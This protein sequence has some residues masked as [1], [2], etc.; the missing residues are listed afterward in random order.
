[1]RAEHHDDLAEQVRRDGHCILPSLFPKSLITEWHRHFEPR[2]RSHI[3]REGHA[4]NRGGARYY[5]TLPFE[6]PFADPFVFADPDILAIVDRLV[7]PDTVMCQ[8]A[9]DTPLMGSDYQE[10]H[11]DA[12]PL[13][14]EWGRE[15]PPFQLAVNVPLVDVTE[16]NGPLETTRGTHLMPRDEALEKVRRGEIPVERVLMHAGD[17]MIRDVRTIHRGTPN[18]TEESR[19]MVVIGYSR[20][21]LHRPEV[22]IRIPRSTW[23]HLDEEHRHLLRF[24]QVV[25]ELGQETGEVYQ[26][27]A[28]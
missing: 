9:T 21:W 7:G 1:M 23:D 19:P 13:F 28:Y 15:T 14:P 26:N 12:P 11:R 3:E 10:W 16:R 22:S 6:P 18:R 17:V 8:L 5:V 20:R 24:N 2:L 25:T 4:Q 27:F